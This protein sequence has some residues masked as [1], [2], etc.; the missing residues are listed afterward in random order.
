MAD[1]IVS[2]FAGLFVGIYV[3]RYLG[4]EQFGVLSYAVSITGI[5]A[6]LGH[7]GLYGIVTRKIVRRPSD[8]NTILGTSF[9]LKFCGVMIGYIA[10]FLYVFFFEKERSVEFWVVLITASSLSFK[11]FDVIDFWFQAHVQAK[12]TA[13]SRSISLLLG[14]IFKI[15]M[16]VIGA[17]L[18]FFAFAAPLQGC[19][20]ACYSII[21]FQTK[22]SF[23]VKNW[24]IN[25]GKAKQLLSE[26]WPVF[27]GSILATI[28]FNI[29]Q[30]MLKW[31]VGVEEVGMYAIAAKFSEVWYFIP[32]AILSS[33]FP[34]LVRLKEKNERHYTYRLQQ[35]FDILFC[36][37]LFIAVL[38]T[39]VSEP[40]ISFFLGD[41]YQASATMLTIHIWAALFV[42]MRAAFSKWILIEN[43][44]IFSLITQGLGTLVNI[45]LNFILIPRYGGYGAAVATLISYAVAS[46]FS[47]F[48]FSDSRSVFWMMSK[49]MLSPIRYLSFIMI[50][51]KTDI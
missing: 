24:N 23:S 39:I 51:R 44:L 25:F 2:L 46:Y 30:V 41:Q 13:I 6:I 21:F 18:I 43:I 49:A 36:L 40:F 1:K 20:M 31:F 38:V 28:Y 19:I 37:A 45:A 17:K 16:V 35:I 47:L 7:A 3:A 11:P 42:F 32:S 27:C 26:S 34:K 15:I 29:D 48:L 12:Y 8:S 14:S 5:F 4:P 9:F 22:S 10:L 50:N 33:L